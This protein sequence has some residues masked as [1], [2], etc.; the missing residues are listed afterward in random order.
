MYHIF[1]NIF[2]PIFLHPAKPHLLKILILVVMSSPEKITITIHNCNSINKR[3]NDEYD[4]N[5]D[6]HTTSQNDNND[7]YNNN[8]D[9][10]SN[11]YINYIRSKL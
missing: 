7:H 9:T 2:S 8:I 4:D 1:L 10:I 5:N 3:N 11:S 6:D